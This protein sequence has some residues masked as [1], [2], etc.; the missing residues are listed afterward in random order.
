MRLAAFAQR[1]IGVGVVLSACAFGVTA[2]GPSGSPAGT[3]TTSAVPTASGDPSSG[4][5]KLEKVTIGVIPL[6]GAASE[7]LTQAI[8][9]LEAGAKVLGWNVQVT[10]PNGVGQKMQ[11]AMSAM[12]ANHDTAIVTMGIDAPLLGPE[13]AAAK[14]AGI[15]VIDVNNG[16]DPATA[17]QY[18]AVIAPSETEWGTVLGNYMKSSLAPAP[19]IE[20]VNAPYTSH[21]MADVAMR[22]ADNAGFS[23]AKIEQ[24]DIT[25]ISASYEAVTRE[26]IQSYPNAKYLLDPG[27]FAAGIVYPVLKLINR[28]DV[29]ILTRYDDTPTINLMKHGAKIVDVATSLY[30]PSLMTLDQ[31]ASFVAKKTPVHSVDSG[32]PFK[33]LTRDNISSY[34]SSGYEYP[35]SAALAKYASKW[36]SEYDLP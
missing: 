4:K 20:E 1:G 7:V 18:S 21:H 35:L 9:G 16:V 10:D 27:D 17:S 19:V 3:S 28:Q 14:S 24:T 6:V 32:F 36:A 5:T 2:C 15:P 13:L 30:L 29:A 23:I 31:L 25:N 22:I 8:D 33:I 26:G 11:S 34:P 12:I